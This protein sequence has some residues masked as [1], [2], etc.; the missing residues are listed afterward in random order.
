MRLLAG[1]SCL[2]PGTTW[3]YVK[4]G[5]AQTLLPDC[6]CSLIVWS[7]GPVSSRVC[8]CSQLVILAQFTAALALKVVQHSSCTISGTHALNELLLYSSLPMVLV[9]SVSR[10]LVNSMWIPVTYCG[11]RTS[12]NTMLG[13][14]SRAP[15]LFFFTA[16]FSLSGLPTLETATY[17][18]PWVNT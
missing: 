10:V 3:N 2:V 13:V 17:S 4:K 5:R 8:Q 9:M 11:R 14:S 1:Y 16:N 12:W 7:L 15:S 6:H 18:C